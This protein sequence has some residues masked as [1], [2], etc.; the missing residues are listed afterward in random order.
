MAEQNG[1][2]EKLIEANPVQQT[3][4]LPDLHRAR[5]KTLLDPRRSQFYRLCAF[6]ILVVP[7]DREVGTQEDVPVVHIFYISAHDKDG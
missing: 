4:D 5:P 3:S 6:Y 7:D 1:L 2:L